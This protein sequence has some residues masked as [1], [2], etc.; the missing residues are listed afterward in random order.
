MCTFSDTN[1]AI[2]QVKP[3]DTHGKH[4]QFGEQRAQPQVTQSRL[5]EGRKYSLEH[6]EPAYNTGKPLKAREPT[7]SSNEAPL[8]SREHSTEEKEPINPSKDPRK[9]TKPHDPYCN[10]REHAHKTEEPHMPPP[11]HKSNEPSNKKDEPPHRI[12]KMVNEMLSHDLH[13]YAM[14]KEGSKYIQE[15]IEQ[16][17]REEKEV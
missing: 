4:Q 8:K 17:S 2:I 6:E 14:Y 7:H 13:I 11:V 9:P 5:E 3:Y 10:D 16:S 15:Q 1:I 12:S